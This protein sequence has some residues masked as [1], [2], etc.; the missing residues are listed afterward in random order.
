MVIYA[1]LFVAS[2]LKGQTLENCAICRTR[3]NSAALGH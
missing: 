2:R 1:F 3:E